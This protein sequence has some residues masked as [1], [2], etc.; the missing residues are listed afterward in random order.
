MLTGDKVADDLV[1]DDVATLRKQL[2][3]FPLVLM[4]ED[5]DESQVLSGIKLGACDF[6]DKPLST[7]KLK[8]IWQ[9]VV[10]RKVPLVVVA[11]GGESNL[12]AIL[13]LTNTIADG[14]R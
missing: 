8:N 9:H 12:C 1:H 3:R 6:L 4:S 5:S 10:R 13:Q 14:G 7:L 11:D 2:V